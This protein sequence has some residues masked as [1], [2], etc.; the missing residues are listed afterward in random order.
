MRSAYSVGLFGMVPKQAGAG[1]KATLPV[2]THSDAFTPWRCRFP[3]EPASWILGTA[4]SHRWWR[5][6]VAGTA[7]PRLFRAFPAVHKFSPDD[8][9]GQR[10]GR[11][12]AFSPFRCFGQP[13][14]VTGIR[15]RLH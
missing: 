12:F 8:V 2:M 3:A 10:I 1:L 5:G 13:R 9:D 14:N 15:L 7:A 6:G 4:H 11:Q